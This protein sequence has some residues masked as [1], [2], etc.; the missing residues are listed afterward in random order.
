MSYPISPASSEK[1]IGSH[2]TL[3]RE[4][5][6]RPK[7]NPPHEKGYGV[8]K[9]AEAAHKLIDIYKDKE[10]IDLFQDSI[11]FCKKF[12]SIIFPAVCGDLKK[13]D[14]YLSTALETCENDLIFPEFFIMDSSFCTHVSKTNLSLLESLENVPENKKRIFQSK[15]SKNKYLSEFLANKYYNIELLVCHQSLSQ[16]VLKCF[17]QAAQNEKIPCTIM[18]N[19][20]II[21]YDQIK[22]ALYFYH[23]NGQDKP[24]CMLFEEP[25]NRFLSPS[26]SSKDL[27]VNL[28]SGN[29]K[30]KNSYQTTKDVW[31]R[32]I[33]DISHACDK[34]TEDDAFKRFWGNINDERDC[35]IFTTPFWVCE[36]MATGTLFLTFSPN[37]Y[38]VPKYEELKRWVEGLC[39]FDPLLAFAAFVHFYVFYGDIFEREEISE[40]LRNLFNTSQFP[41]TIQNFFNFFFDP[42]ISHSTLVPF[43]E[44]NLFI[45]GL[46]SKNKKSLKVECFTWEGSNSLLWQW[47]KGIVLQLPFSCEKTI[48][49]LLYISPDSA[50]P[51]LAYTS[52]FFPPTA[53][54][55]PLKSFLE[56]FSLSSSTLYPLILKLFNSQNPLLY[57]LGLHLL[58]PEVSL[59]ER[60]G[61]FLALAPYFIASANRQHFVKII[62]GICS[63]KFIAF[64]QSS[65][66][67]F[68]I[69]LSLLFQEKYTLLKTFFKLIDTHQIWKKN[70]IFFPF[71]KYF[72]FLETLCAKFRENKG[73]WI[74]KEDTIFLLQTFNSILVKQSSSDVFKNSLLTDRLKKGI[75]WYL[76]Q[77]SLVEGGHA[78]RFLRY[79]SSEFD[80]LDSEKKEFCISLFL[81]ALD[82]PNVDSSS[83]CGELKSPMIWKSLDEKQKNSINNKSK[84]DSDRDKRLARYNDRKSK[85]DYFY[86]K[87]ELSNL[88]SKYPNFSK[89][90]D[91]VLLSEIL[92]LKQKKEGKYD[93][94]LFELWVE[95]LSIKELMAF[96][97]A[98]YVSLFKSCLFSFTAFD[99]DLKEKIQ[100]A[101]ACYCKQIQHD[102]TAL[103]L[104]IAI[105]NKGFT[106]PKKSECARF[107]IRHLSKNLGEK[108]EKWEGIYDLYLF[109]RKQSCAELINLRDKKNLLN[110]L[111][112]NALKNESFA[113]VK[114]IVLE[115]LDIL[116]GVKIYLIYPLR[117]AQTAYDLL[118]AKRE[119]KSALDFLLII[120]RHKIQEE[121]FLTGAILWAIREL[122]WN[123]DEVLKDLTFFSHLM[124][125]LSEIEKDWKKEEKIVTLEYDRFTIDLVNQ[126]IADFL[127]NGTTSI[128]S[129]KSAVFLIDAFYFLFEDIDDTKKEILGALI[130]SCEN[131]ELKDLLVDILNLGSKINIFQKN[132]SLW[133]DLCKKING[134]LDASTWIFLLE[135]LPIFKSSSL[136]RVELYSFLEFS[137]DLFKY[138]L[139][140]FRETKQLDES[141][142]RILHLK[143]DEIKNTL[144]L[145]LQKEPEKLS[146]QEEP[147][148]DEEDDSELAEKSGTENSRLFILGQRGRIANYNLFKDPKYL[149]AASPVIKKFDLLQIDTLSFFLTRLK[150]EKY[151]EA[152]TTTIIRW[153]DDF[154][155]EPH[156]GSTLIRCY[157]LCNSTLTRL[158]YED[159]TS[160]IIYFLNYFMRTIDLKKI[161]VR[162]LFYYYIQSPK[163]S[164]WGFTLIGNIICD[165]RK[166]NYSLDEINE[167]AKVTLFL[168]GLEQSP[169]DFDYSLK[170]SGSLL[171]IVADFF[172]ETE[173]SSENRS[174][175]KYAYHS[176]LLKFH[177]YKIDLGNKNQKIQVL[178]QAMTFIKSH[179]YIEGLTPCLVGSLALLSE[180]SKWDIGCPSTTIMTIF[181]LL[182]FLEILDKNGKDMDLLKSEVFNLMVE[183]LYGK[184]RFEYKKD[185]YSLALYVCTTYSRLSGFINSLEQLMKAIDSDKDFS[186]IQSWREENFAIENEL[187][188]VLKLDLRI[189]NLEKEKNSKE[190]LSEKR[191]KMIDELKNIM[192]MNWSSLDKTM[193]DTFYSCFILKMFVHNRSVYKEEGDLF[194]DTFLHLLSSLPYKWTSRK[195]QNWMYLIGQVLFSCYFKEMDT[196]FGKE[197]INKNIGKIISFLLHADKC[198]LFDSNLEILYAF[199]CATASL[200]P[201]AS[202]RIDSLQPNFPSLF[203]LYG[204]QDASSR[205]WHLPVNSASESEYSLTRWF[206]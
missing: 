204:E 114:E 92:E 14:V 180:I 185:F 87:H 110:L 70:S 125:Q 100:T 43:L 196:E 86:A 205:E 46:H 121:P 30:I 41:L 42:D 198:N 74:K 144:E 127:K 34:T 154:I 122:W 31:I 97:N 167:I 132:P 6:T 85:E 177:S 200:N 115:M 137:E 4:G 129:M 2:T 183:H 192:K 102:E 12:I 130:K 90:E 117:H 65:D 150:K 51:L 83:L 40:D 104:L 89:E 20:I 149:N 141:L 142:E 61:F 71:T 133:Y 163:T 37:K 21:L 169:E 32:T 11:T 96:K 78:L 138:T 67:P 193:Y 153:L 187:E 190:I 105:K 75:P 147:N 101:I 58:T 8:G 143:I 140:F 184:A 151:T 123:Q 156:T 63:Q 164:L 91:L 24:F 152:K 168:L 116:K 84:S 172:K 166:K 82:L 29:S 13:L 72:E 27:E 68:E 146:L 159:T 145:S 1:K 33:L 93:R 23:F 162:E 107:W 158:E 188:K 54:D 189:G 175:L 69:L 179:L 80:S 56:S 38:D 155:C 195:K 16:L 44:I 160:R 191:K 76:E 108:P 176:L 19:Q 161:N 170:L 28:V 73:G 36:K 119:F 26:D 148:T 201:D 45:A 120:A 10:K 15:L 199:L 173:I 106:L 111:A 9:K 174:D 62:S 60:N 165:S 48:E 112:S 128:D 182:D 57:F 49:N 5:N 50:S 59:V 136:K 35:D 103:P 118:N 109:F 202:K 7:E 126:L 157:D 47:E 94:D 171:Q 53:F 194:L 134:K 113:K 79:L 18:K 203:N 81:K 88:L 95:R 135:K 55:E 17:Q 66:L 64:T 178:N 206:I 139:K 124:K 131:I 77:L 181:H 39:S 98:K 186:E 197:H 22:I 99:G 52:I 3:R 25:I